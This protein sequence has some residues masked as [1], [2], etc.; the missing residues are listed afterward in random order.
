MSSSRRI[1]NPFYVVLVLASIAFTITACAY[2]VMTVRALKPDP[3]AAASEHEDGLLDFLNR[4]GA[5]LLFVELAVL[6]ISAVLAM[7]TEQYW[8]N[9]NAATKTC[10]DGDQKHAERIP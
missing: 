9:R 7:S 1:A 3:A 6:G 8:S 2:G 10:L 4:H 5:P